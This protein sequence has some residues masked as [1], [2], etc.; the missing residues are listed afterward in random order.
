MT[1]SFGRA[2]SSDPQDM[3]Q[4]AVDV[5]GSDIAARA[6]GVADP[7]TPKQW[8]S[9]TRSVR[10]HQTLL[11]LRTVHLVIEELK[12]SLTDHEVAAWFTLFNPDL[13]CKAALQVLDEEP[14]EESGG[15]VLQAALDFT[16][17]RR[18]RKQPA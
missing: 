8:A 11:R 18:E 6:L 10:G 7:R 14:F 15:L 16:A 13:G 2:L 12:S 4:R 3:A 5:L 1:P 9:G 17:S